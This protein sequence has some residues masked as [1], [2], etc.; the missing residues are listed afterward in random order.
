MGAAAGTTLTAEELEA[1]PKN[2][3]CPCGSGKKFKMCH[4]RQGLSARRRSRLTWGG[5]ALDGRRLSRPLPRLVSA[6]AL[7]ASPDMAQPTCRASIRQRPSSP[8][9]R[10]ARARTRGPVEHHGA[11]LGHP[12]GRLAHPDAAHHGPPR[13][14]HAAPG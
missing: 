6:G 3:P 8:T 14:G 2:A 1:T 12:V 7:L 4:G 11:R 5:A 9:S 13:A 10:M